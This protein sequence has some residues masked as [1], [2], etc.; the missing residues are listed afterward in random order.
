MHE[1]LDET[2]ASMDEKIAKIIE[3]DV[4]RLESLV[5]AGKFPDQNEIKHV[6]VRMREIGEGLK[7]LAEGLESY[8]AVTKAIKSDAT[9][10][11]TC[12]PLTEPALG[13]QCYT[14]PI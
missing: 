14:G 10:V 9:P 7:A 8:R 2:L 5:T 6:T 1:K 12:E 3:S 4:T 13:G 11:K